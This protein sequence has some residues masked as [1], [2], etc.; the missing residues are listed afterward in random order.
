MT[1]LALTMGEP[2]GVGPELA[3]R[4]WTALKATGPCFALLAPPGL[5]DARAR[6]LGL[7]VVIAGTGLAEAAAAF[8]EAL[9][10]VPLEAAA[11]DRPGTADPAGAAAVIESIDRAVAA[12]LRGE[13]R[14]VVTNPIQKASL[15]AAG[16]AHPGHTEY[17]GA[18]ARAAGHDA[19]PVMMLAAGDFRVVP[20]TVHIAL[21]AVPERLTTGLVVETGRIVGRELRARFGIER[22]RLA[23]AGL[24]PH[25]GEAGAMGAEDEAVIRP[26]VEQ[27][28]REGVD[29]VGP[30]PADTMFHTR[31]RAGYD[32][33]LCMYHDQALIP[34]KTVAFDDAVNVTLGLPFVRTSPDHGTALD[35]AGKGVARADSLIAA[36]RLAGRLA[37]A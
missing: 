16:F 35:I 10:V 28:R 32:A 11:P 37:P 17:L 27:L 6:A 9:P 4:A 2:G 25:A 18:L 20:V 34:I 29:A 1:P 5:I 33:A 24:N 14:G 15:Y 36:L 21:A 30:L 31:A 13:A 8:K 3:I 19:T 23:V 26:A 22:P 7:T 12:V